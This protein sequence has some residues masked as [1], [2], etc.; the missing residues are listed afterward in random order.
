M[1]TGTAVGSYIFAFVVLLIITF[2][3]RRMIVGWR[4]RGERQEELIG[5][6]PKLPD[7]LGS[8]I[9][10][11][12]PGLY[13]GCILADSDGGGP[14]WLDRIAVGDLAYRSKGVLTRYP[15]GIL[16]VRSGARAIWIPEES[17]SLIR[18]E[19]ALAGKVIPSK[20]RGEES[21]GGVLAIR[22][23]LPSGTLIDTGFR[24]DDRREH[25][26]WIGDVA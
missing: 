2:A 16:L 1:N 10:P 4:R 14:D 21:A 7:L 12:L 15:H 18:T 24:G 3:I 8:A 9:L 22:W 11:P 13:I 20:A 17:I 6:L 25:D 19:T 26:R 5:E 23:R